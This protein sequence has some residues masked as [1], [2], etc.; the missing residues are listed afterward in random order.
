[1]KEHVC[2]RN[3]NDFDGVLILNNLITLAK[4]KVFFQ[5]NVSMLFLIG[6]KYP[7]ELQCCHHAD[8][9]STSER[10]NRKGKR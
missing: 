4:K 1:M 9:G 10:K 2:F 7:C 5:L 6:S 8:G 3:E